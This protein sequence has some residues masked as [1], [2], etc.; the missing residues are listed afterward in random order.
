MA[1]R[2]TNYTRKRDPSLDY[3]INKSIISSKIRLVGENF[4]EISEVAGK[5][6]ES[7]VYPTAEVLEWAYE[8]G[9]DVVVI[10]PNANPP[11]A[12]VIDFR[13]FLYQKKK[14]EKEIKSNTAKTVIKEIRFGPNTDEHDF[15]FKTRHA[16]RFLEE[17]AKVKAYV[18]FRGRT[19]VFKDRGELLLLKFLKNLESF[20]TAENLP[21]MEGRRM[22]V[23]VSP[24]KK[25]STKK[26]VTKKETSKKDNA[27]KEAA[28]KEVS[29]VDT[30]KTEAQDVQA[31]D[32]QAQDVKAQ[33]VQAQNVQAPKKE[34][35]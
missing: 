31:Q 12:R 21:K 3:Q 18:H 20:G 23:I 6:I 25:A 13:K 35:E 26:K 4:D 7:E 5:T 2:R 8:L 34:I 10:S 33:D 22:T 24:T 16:Q 11:V 27:K 15:E 29:K 1:R 17:G 30:P 14:K 19:I 28:K 9:M 32:V